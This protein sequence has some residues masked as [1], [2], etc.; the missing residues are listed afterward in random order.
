MAKEEKQDAKEK[1]VDEANALGVKRSN[2]KMTSF[3]DKD[4]TRAAR[5]AAKLEKLADKRVENR[6][7]KAKKAANMKPIDKRRDLLKA[8]LK[9]VKD[10][11]RGITYPDKSLMAWIEELKLITSSPKAWN[12]AT[13]KGTA[14]YV[15]GNKKKQTTEDILAN[16]DLD[17]E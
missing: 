14:N 2:I 12:N 16:M 3:K 1:L 4:P 8:R 9:A 15:P 6:I 11:R 7:A 13:K 5:E 10:K 17:T